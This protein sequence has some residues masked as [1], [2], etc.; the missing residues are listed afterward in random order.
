MHVAK[1]ILSSRMSM[2]VSRVVNNSSIGSDGDTFAWKSKWCRQNRMKATFYLC[3][4]KL[5]VPADSLQEQGKKNEF[6]NSKLRATVTVS[7]WAFSWRTSIASETCGTVKAGIWC[8]GNRKDMNSI[9]K[10]L[11]NEY[12]QFK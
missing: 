9:Q 6:A 3:E 12:C 5:N 10:I 1:H 4:K 2:H 7:S 8:F 11:E